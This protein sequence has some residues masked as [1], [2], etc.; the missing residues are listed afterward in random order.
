MPIG[1][2]HPTHT[3]KRGS[4]GSGRV[5]EVLQPSDEQAPKNLQKTQK[6]ATF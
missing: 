2:A 3:P 5:C 1:C 6:R 4:Q